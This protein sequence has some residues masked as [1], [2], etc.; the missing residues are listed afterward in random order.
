MTDIEAFLACMEYH[1]A[2]HRPNHELG[3][4]NQTKTRWEKESW[5][6]VKDFQW[7]W[8]YGEEGLQLDHRDYIPVNY[9]FIPEFKHIY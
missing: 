7:N 3:V 5:Q 8:F 4:W 1:P 9:G 6:S 2:T